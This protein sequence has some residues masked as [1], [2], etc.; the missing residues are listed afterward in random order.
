VIVFAP[1]GR[2]WDVDRHAPWLARIVIDVTIAAM[3]AT[4]LLIVIFW[5]SRRPLR[6]LLS[7]LGGVYGVQIARKVITDF[8]FVDRPFVVHH[9]VALYPH[10]AD[11][12]FPSS[13]T[14]YFAA[15][16][17]PMFIGWRRGGW[18]MGL[19]TLEIAAGCVY[20]GV[21]YGTDVLAGALIGVGSSA[22]AYGV[23]SW[24]PLARLVAL[25]DRWLRRWRIRPT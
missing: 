12:S 16:A 18:L 19:I 1:G 17:F 21:H 3:C 4:G 22:A 20:V 9:F 13:L 25:V 7:M 24:S 11:S 14:G 6:N 2:L 8:L 15:V 5:F 10:I 23:L